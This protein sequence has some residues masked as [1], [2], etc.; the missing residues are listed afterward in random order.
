LKGIKPELLDR[1]LWWSA[2]VLSYVVTVGLA[3]WL[4]RVYRRRPYGEPDLYR[5]DQAAGFMLGGAKG[6]IIAMLFASS[7]QHYAL[8]YVQKVGGWPEQQ[9][10]TSYSLAWNEKYHPAARLW[11]LAPVQN[12]VA[13]VQRMGL[14]PPADGTQEAAVP[15]VQTASRPRSLEIP[16]DGE[17]GKERDPGASGLKDIEN[18]ETVIDR[19][20]DE[21]RGDK[22]SN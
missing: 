11:S 18:L 17:F 12:F 19:M 22:R 16:R 10:Q 5:G 4:V 13:Y 6:A 21:L 9:A 8:G 15:P 1:L 20:R 14:T 7:L 2:C 3:T